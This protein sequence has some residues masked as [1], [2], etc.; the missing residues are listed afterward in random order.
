[1]SELSHIKLSDLTRQ[2][3]EVI[4]QSFGDR[5]FWIVAEI[6][7]HKFYPD[8]DRHYFDLVEKIENS[9][10]EAAKVKGH[11][12]TQGSQRISVFEK[13]TGEKFSDGLKVLIN[14]RVNYHIAYGLSLTLRDIDQGFT[15]GDLERKRRETLIRLV[16]DNFEFIQLV[17]ET[18]ITRNKQLKLN[19]VI[20]KIALIGSPK[21]EG[22]TD[23][24]HT[25]T[26]NQFNYRFSINNYYS[27]VQGSG[28][29]QELVN[30]LIQV[31][32]DQKKEQYDCVVIIRGGGSKTDFLVFDTYSLARIAAKFPI[33]I[34]T[35]IG[36]H[37][38]TSIVD[39]M[40]HTQTK[41]PTKAAEFIVAQ[42]RTFEEKV[43]VFQKSIIIK[44]QQL[45]SGRNKQINAFNTSI[46]NKSKHL[47]SVN[48]DFLVTV[49]QR[50]INKSRQ[51]LIQ[52][53]RSLLNFYHKL[54]SNPTIIVGNK[55]RDLANLILNI[56]SFSSKYLS[57]QKG[58][59]GHFASVV[60]LMSPNNILK[61]GFAI[62]SQNDKIVT[63]PDQ[64]VIGSEL[65]V[66]M[67]ETD[68]GSTVK[69]K[70][71]NNGKYNV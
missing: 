29:E 53:Q 34:I 21:S 2:I 48:K 33:P 39:L 66:T 23:F 45:L 71:K 11:S 7:G 17:G 26:S 64:I 13:E 61:K 14:V 4:N 31:F 63:N 1:M 5:T 32:S 12:W 59:L 18:Y 22:Y 27:S 24:V 19:A 25:I 52:Q 58:Y 20:Q 40:I 70:S 47:L 9:S 57:N 8:K 65:I 43:L 30:T 60:R 56:R 46:I 68:I 10:A 41:T 49:N 51:L 55:N 54:T 36:H 69:S 28:A 50:T 67:R 62:V 15:L 38:D 16:K 35:G 44:I 37:K 3:E 42:N 6:S